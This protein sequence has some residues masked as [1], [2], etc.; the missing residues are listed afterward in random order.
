MVANTYEHT[1]IENARKQSLTAS[2]VGA[3]GYAEIVALAGVKLPP[4]PPDFFYHHIRRNVAATLAIEEDEVAELATETAV[5]AKLTAAE[6]QWLDGKL[7]TSIS[8][9]EQ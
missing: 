8:E 2:A 9:N 5:R 1:A 4:R 3:M 7:A 6:K